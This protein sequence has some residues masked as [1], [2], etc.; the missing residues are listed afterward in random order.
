VPE[1]VTVVVP[2]DRELGILLETYVHVREVQPNSLASQ[3]GIMPGDIVLQVEQPVDIDCRLL[4][5]D[6]F[7]CLYLSVCH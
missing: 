4:V 2:S 6:L 1:L 3:R 7:G 5:A